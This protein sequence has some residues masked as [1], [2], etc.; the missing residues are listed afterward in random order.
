MTPSGAEAGL[1][2]GF[3][4][5]SFMGTGGYGSPSVVKVNV[6]ASCAVLI[7]IIFYFMKQD[8]ELSDLLLFISFQCSKY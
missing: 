3:S 4:E 5:P 8:R 1:R 6:I 7:F 2:A